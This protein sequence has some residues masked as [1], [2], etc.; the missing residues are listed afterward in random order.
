MIHEHVTFKESGLRERTEKLCYQAMEILND[1]AEWAKAHG[2]PLV[3]TASVSSPEEDHKLCRISSTHREARAFDLS[4]HGWLRVAI[5]EFVAHFEAKYL[6]VAAL[7]PKTLAPALI[8]VHD[9]GH[10]EHMHV[11]LAKVFAIK[12]PLAEEI[13]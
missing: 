4:I 3:V 5:H 1:M 2:L 6:H 9:N 11:Q 12:D 10:G 7:S 13:V 8:V